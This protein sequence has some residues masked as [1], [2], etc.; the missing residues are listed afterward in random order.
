MNVRKSFFLF[1]L[2]VLTIT[3]YVLAETVDL[4]GKVQNQFGNPVE[5]A[6]LKL[7][8]DEE[9]VAITDSDGQF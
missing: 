6:E 4:I 2:I 9:I 8:S 1:G 5:G 7:L 3:S